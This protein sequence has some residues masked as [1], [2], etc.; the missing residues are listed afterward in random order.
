MAARLRLPPPTEEQ[1]EVVTA[2]LTSRLVLAGAGS[3]K[4]ATMAD[5]VVWL[6]AN[7]LVRPDEVLGVTFTRK[8]AGELAERINGR[9]DAL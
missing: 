3:G 4:T 7:G 6:V 9:V 5:R 1:A 8:A 2:P